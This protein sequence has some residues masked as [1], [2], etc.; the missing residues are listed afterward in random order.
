M[1]LKIFITILMLAFP[2]LMVGQGSD[3][4]RY[5]GYK[6]VGVPPSN[7]LPNGVTHLGGGMIGDFNADPV[8]GVSQVQRGRT[9]MLWF[10]VS[11][12][13]DNTGVT[14]WRVMDVLSFPGVTRADH[15]VIPDDP[16]ILCRRN[17]KEI[18]S[19][20][21][22]G[23][24]NMRRGIFTPSRLWVADLKTKKFVPL[25]L[26]GVRCEFSAP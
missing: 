12:G 6:Y 16:S 10:E 20:A 19:L 9:K 13:Q 7:R 15:V 22:V 24:I 25:N 1:K 5:V 8:Y 18:T 26:A 17:R 2:M 23:R 11:T 3:R 21:G 14:G 4:A